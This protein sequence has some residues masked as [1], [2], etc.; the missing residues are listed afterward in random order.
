MQILQLLVTMIST[1]SAGLFFIISSSS[2]AANYKPKPV[3]YSTPARYK[4]EFAKKIAPP[5]SYKGEVQF[6]PAAPPPVMPTLFLKEGPYLGVA[7]GYDSYKIHQLTSFTGTTS[8][9]FNP[10]LNATGFIPALMAGYGHYFKDVLYLALEVFGN[11]S[12]AY[13]S[14]NY[15]INDTTDNINYNSKFFV[16]W[17]Y[18]VNFLPGIKFTDSALAFLRLGYQMARLRGQENL[19]AD[20]I[21]QPINTSSWSG[22]FSYG[23]GFEEAMIGNFSLR[24]EYSHTDY[25][26]FTATSGTKYFPSNNQFLLS[27]IYHLAF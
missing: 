7:A 27:L 22:G 25:R 15:V 19:M 9:T 23:M 18:G 17:G 24:G 13:Q 5:H 8:S 6:K 2:L 3:Y 1:L 20:G 4:G 26:A 10:N 11:Y 21:I 14:T 16:S 12:N